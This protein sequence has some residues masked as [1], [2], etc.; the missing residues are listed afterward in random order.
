MADGA[1]PALLVSCPPSVPALHPPVKSVN[2]FVLPRWI[3]GLTFWV[4][5]PVRGRTSS[6]Q[7]WG[8]SNSAQTCLLSLHWYQTMTASESWTQTCAWQQRRPRHHPGYGWQLSHPLQPILYFFASLGSF[9]YPQNMNHGICLSL[10]YP[11]PDLLTIVLLCSALQ[12]A[13]TVC[14]FSLEPKADRHR[15]A[16]GSLFFFSVHHGDE[17]NQ[18]SNINIL[19]TI[20]MVILLCG[21]HNHE[22]LCIMCFKGH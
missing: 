22:K 10:L 4:L 1:L 9:L 8:A 18:A 3:I 15:S 7:W 2:S 21:C 20:S 19:I 5:R 16:S 11:I 17:Q 13:R 12:G 14:V 6:S